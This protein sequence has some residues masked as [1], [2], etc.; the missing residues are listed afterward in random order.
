ML[1]KYIYVKRMLECGDDKICMHLR[2]DQK[3]VALVFVLQKRGVQ[4]YWQLAI[5]WACVSSILELGKP[6][7]LSSLR[8]ETLAQHR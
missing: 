8:V 4:S 2:A 1:F 5:A 7:I 3:A 6:G